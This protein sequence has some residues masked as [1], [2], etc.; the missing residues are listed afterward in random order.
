MQ[1]VEHSVHVPMYRGARFQRSNPSLSSPPLR[2]V[3]YITIAL[4][5]QHKRNRTAG[6]I[7][8]AEGPLSASVLPVLFF[9]QMR[10]THNAALVS[11]NP[12]VGGYGVY[13][14]FGGLGGYTS[15]IDPAPLLK[16]RLSKVCRLV[17]DGD[18]VSGSW[19][20][21]DARPLG[22]RR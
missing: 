16:G 2:D 20:C 13:G 22:F 9:L 12:A 3:S 5:D 18:K 4:A 6:N 1:D 15:F 7:F 8:S 21:T 17:T 10:N 11:Q 19:R 14:G